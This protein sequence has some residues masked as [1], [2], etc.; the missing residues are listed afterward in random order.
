MKFNEYPESIDGFRRASKLGPP[1]AENHD[2]DFDYLIYERVVD[3]YLGC[4]TAK[5]LAAGKRQIRKADLSNRVPR[6]S[7]RIW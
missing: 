3:G 5:D 7:S 4:V 2:R 6:P 1:I